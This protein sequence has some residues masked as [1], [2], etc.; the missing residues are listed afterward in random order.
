[1]KELGRTTWNDTHNITPLSRT[2]RVCHRRLAVGRSLHGGRI[3][4]HT[5]LCGAIWQ[6]KFSWKKNYSTSLGYI[7]CYMKHFVR[8]G[9]ICIT[10]KI[11]QS[12]AYKQYA[13]IEWN[14]PFCW[15]LSLRLDIP[16]RWDTSPQINTHCNFQNMRTVITSNLKLKLKICSDLSNMGIKWPWNTL[17]WTLE[18]SKSGKSHNQYF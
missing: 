18:N 5:I 15:D 6:K 13:F 8:F 12:I 7:H 1:M 16:L 2:P 10:W 17:T 11:A 4:T 3:Y 9:T 14:S